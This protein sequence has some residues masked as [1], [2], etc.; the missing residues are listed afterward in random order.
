MFEA[1]IRWSQASFPDLPWRRRRSLYRTLVS[2]IM[3]Q[4]TTVATV[5]RHFEAFVV[6]FPDVASLAEASEDELLVAWKGLGYYRRAR[7]LKKIAETIARDHEGK[8]PHDPLE[9]QRIPGIGPYTANALVAMGMDRSALAVDANL[10]RV[11]ARLYGVKLPK[12]VAL[13]KK[14]LAMYVAGEILPERHHSSR[15][16]NEALMDLGRTVCQARKVACE[17]CPLA[18]DCVARRSGKPLGFPLDAKGVPKATV[19]HRLV[20][21]RVVVARGDEVLA[22]Q[23][24]EDEWLS[25]QWELPTFVVNST[26]EAF[27]QYPPLKR[28]VAWE[29]LPEVKTGITKYHISN[30]VLALSAKEWTEWKF[31]PATHWRSRAGSGNLS[32]ASSKAL[33]ALQPPARKTRA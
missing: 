33:A 5:R 23:K 27:R 7:N 15:A 1:L 4:Q 28:R 10:E 2:E 24:A 12:G 8:F 29:E 13:Q 19:E 31:G 32:T 14:L 9:L 11:L 22:Y 18:S 20:L 30:R 16:L 21:L 6:Q 17:L 26:D 25:G 3:L